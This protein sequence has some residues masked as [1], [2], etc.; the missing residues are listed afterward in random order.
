M[1]LASTP[2][3]A[4]GHLLPERTA[5]TSGDG[6]MGTPA[7]VIAVASQDFLQVSRRGKAA[8]DLQGAASITRHRLL[9]VQR[10]ILPSVGRPKCRRLRAGLQVKEG[11]VAPCKYRSVAVSASTF[12]E[13]KYDGSELLTA[14][15][16]LNRWFGAYK[17]ELQPT[18]SFVQAL[19]QLT[20]S[21]SL[22]ELDRYTRLRHRFEGQKN[23]AALSTG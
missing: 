11:L 12:Q 10:P 7:P 21:L 1:G 9:S 16:V 13:F 22:V 14:K 15:T 19:G 3:V 5:T 2:Q 4:T 17:D 8:G 6:E 20:P 18:R 23:A